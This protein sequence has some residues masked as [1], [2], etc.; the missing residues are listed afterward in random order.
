MDAC[1]TQFK[2]FKK[3]VQRQNQKILWKKIKT[4]IKIISVI[5][6]D[7]VEVWW[8][9]FLQTPLFPGFSYC[10]VFGKFQGVTFE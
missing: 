6:Y 3:H 8:G 4:H 5:T 9:V 10:A 7:P 1:D 2:T